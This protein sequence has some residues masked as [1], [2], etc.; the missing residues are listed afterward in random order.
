MVK[1][2]DLCATAGYGPFGTAVNEF[3]TSVRSFRRRVA[4]LLLAAAMAFG[5]AFQ[6]ASFVPR[7]VARCS[8]TLD[9]VAYS[10]HEEASRL[11]VPAI[12]KT[13]AG[14][15]VTLQSSFGASGNQS[16]KRFEGLPVDLDSFSLTRGEQ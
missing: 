2:G 6:A 1:S 15:G 10:T 3:V 9:L 7:V 14:Q 5:L 12:E 4:P 8:A 11:L 13:K 16:R